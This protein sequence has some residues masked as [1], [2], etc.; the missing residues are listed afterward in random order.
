MKRKINGKRIYFQKLFC[1]ASFIFLT[2][3]CFWYGGRFIY[4]YLDSV[5]TEK[6]INNNLSYVVISN[7]ELKDANGSHYFYGN[8][9]NNYIK[10]SNVL[11]R[12]IKVD[13]DN[14]VYLISDNVISYLNNGSE[15]YINMWLN[16]GNIPNSG[17][18]ENNLNDTDNYLINYSV[19]NDVVN[20]INNLTC[21]DINNDYLIGLLSVIDYVNT[22]GDKGFINNN[23][24]TFLSNYNDT[25]NKWYINDEGKLGVSENDDIYGIKPVIK[26]NGNIKLVSGNGT[27][28]YPYVIEEATTLFGSYVKLGND[29]WRVYNIDGDNIKLILDDYLIV[30]NEKI[31]MRYSN[32]NYQYNDS[33]SNSLAYYLNNDYLNSL[34]Y[35]DIILSSSWSNYYY[36][37]ENSYNY[38]DILNNKI[39]TKVSVISVG[40]V[41]FNDNNLNKFYTNTGINTTENL[42]YTINGNGTI[43]KRRVNYPSYVVPVISINKGVLTKGNGTIDVPY[44]MG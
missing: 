1:F 25:N 2:T 24:Y 16:D 10:Y 42:I 40:D 21:N 41:I 19:C 35:K 9:V 26:I 13:N 14:S 36:G 28:K 22:G 37:I 5:K 27:N 8:D 44:E 39:D 6:E 15:N 11:W 31:E 33:I 18:L 20:D 7:N 12:I 29:I 34:S 3:C 23:K 38:L 4:F 43:S 17:I 30:D 32:T